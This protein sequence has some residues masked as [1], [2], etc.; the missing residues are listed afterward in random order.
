MHFLAESSTGAGLKKMLATSS[1]LHE[2]HIVSG[3]PGAPPLIWRGVTL[4]K[5]VMLDFRFL[6]V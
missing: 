3:S 2:D 4:Y 1:S 5:I 6:F